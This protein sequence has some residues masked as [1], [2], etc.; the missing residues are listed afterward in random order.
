MAL[1]GDLEATKGSSGAIRARLA[2]RGLAKGTRAATAGLVRGRL[3]LTGTTKGTSVPPVEP[4]PV[5]PLSAIDQGRTL[6]AV[7]EG[8][9]LT[10]V[11]SAFTLTAILEEED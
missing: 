8:R 7:D 4:P 2:F 3:G 5:L 9:T 6:T 1:R 10:A 11:P